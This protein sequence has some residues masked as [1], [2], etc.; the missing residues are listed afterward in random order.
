MNKEKH[1]VTTLGVKAKKYNNNKIPGPII[2]NKKNKIELNEFVSY[3]KRNKENYKESHPLLRAF[4]RLQSN[5]L[6]L[7]PI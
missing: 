7:V 5:F 2:F 6:I 4:S 1:G 3:N